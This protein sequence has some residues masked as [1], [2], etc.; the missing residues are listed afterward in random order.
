MACIK[1]THFFDNETLNRLAPDYGV[2]HGWFDDDGKRL[3]GRRHPISLYWTPAQ[4]R[5]REYKSC[6]KIHP[7]LP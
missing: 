2:L 3:H 6:L 5:M 7:D 1:V 4:Y